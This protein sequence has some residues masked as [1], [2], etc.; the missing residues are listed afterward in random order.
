MSDEKQKRIE[1]FLED[2]PIRNQEIFENLKALRGE[3]RA[4]VTSELA[5]LACMVQMLAPCFPTAAIDLA[6]VCGRLHAEI[7]KREGWDG[8][9]M[10]ADIEMFIEARRMKK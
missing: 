1:Q 2:A 7:R 8:P 5:N 10:L 6:E 9:E 4:I 3:H